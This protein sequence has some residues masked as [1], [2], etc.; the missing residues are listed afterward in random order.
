MMDIFGIESA[1]LTG[2][3]FDVVRAEISKF[4]MRV[5]IVPDAK[6]ENMARGKL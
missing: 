2:G 1:A 5:Q 4:A 6:D 3:S